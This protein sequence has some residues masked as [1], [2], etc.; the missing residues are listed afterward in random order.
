MIDHA[1]SIEKAGLGGERTMLVDGERVA[2]ARGA[3]FDAVD[4]TT[5]QHL[6]RV[7]CAGAEDVDR[8]VAAARR[9]FARGPWPEASPRRRAEALLSLAA[10]CRAHEKDLAR[11]EALDVG[12]PRTLASR[13]S[14][15]ALV[16]NLE[17]YAGWTDKLYGEV[18]PA[19]ARTLD[20][21]R[22]EPFGVIA[23][24]IP[25]NTPL[26]MAGAKLGPALATGNTVILKPSE[27]ACL[28]ALALADL[29]VEA[30]LPPGVVQVLTGDASTGALLVGHPGIDKVSFTGGGAIA[31]DVLA[32]AA[33]NLTPTSL[34]LGGKSAQVVFA[35]ADLDAAAM[36]ITLG[37][38][39]LTGQACAAGSRL[40]VDRG[41]HDRLVERVCEAAGTLTVGDPLDPATLIGPLVSRAHHAKVEARIR[42]GLDAGARLALRAP[43]PDGLPP[44]GSFLPPHVFTGVS[45]DMALWREEVFGPVL[46]V[47]PF[48]GEDEAI[49]L[50]NDT[51][52][53]LAA[54]VWTRDGA[55]AH[56]VAEALRAGTVWVNQYGALPVSAP[57][58]GFGRSG[59]GREGGRDALAEYTQI[60]NVNMSIE[61]VDA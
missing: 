10:L 50:A 35:D 15:G 52:Y 23:A 33:R 26:L 31:R 41:M 43:L 49:A 5:G 40:L 28:S 7:P 27:S 38:F 16:R 6:G 8:A 29:V 3:A 39:G 56:R 12:M 37:I 45:P 1:S 61:H 18:V 14:V 30:G 13:L 57:F 54:G 36:A 34:E 21:T 55:R 9:A 48:D 60:K 59:W 44:A 42:A 20:Y 58:G 46:C 17:Y 47:A 4:P 19:G 53:G 32:A 24:V 22:R 11:V 2:A 25:W 51:A